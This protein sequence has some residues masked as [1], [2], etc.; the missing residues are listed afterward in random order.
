AGSGSMAS[1]LEAAMET[2][3][4]VFHRYSAREGD[5]RKLSR[6]ELRELLRRELGGF[7]QRQCDAGT[8]EGILRELDEDGDGELDFQEYVALVAALTVA[9]NAVFWERG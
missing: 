4:R 5:R 3:I 2:L 1:R 8:V 9:C 7:L 6:A